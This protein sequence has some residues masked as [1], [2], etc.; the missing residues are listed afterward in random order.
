MPNPLAPSESAVAVPR[1]EVRG[2]K[3]RNPASRLP[4]YSELV[5]GG[6]MVPAPGSDGVFPTTLAPRFSMSERFF[7]RASKNQSSSAKTR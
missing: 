4:A 5:G 1:F 7:G 2:W 3:A 6:I